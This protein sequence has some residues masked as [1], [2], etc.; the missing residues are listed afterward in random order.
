[1]QNEAKTCEKFILFVSQKAAKIMHNG[2]RFA[3]ISHVAEKKNLSQKGTPFAFIKVFTLLLK[4]YHTVL[5]HK[6]LDILMKTTRSYCTNNHMKS[7]V[8]K[9]SIIVLTD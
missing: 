5:G 3:S 4:Q 2:L 6:Y 7:C 9:Y 1:M 8:V